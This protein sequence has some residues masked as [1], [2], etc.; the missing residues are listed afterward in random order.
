MSLMIKSSQVCFGC[1]ITNPINDYIGNHGSKSSSILRYCVTCRDKLLCDKKECTKCKLFL[2]ITKFYLLARA[3]SGLTSECIKCA[4]AVMKKRK[5]PYN[6]HRY[7]ES[8][9]RAL[10]KYKSNNKEKIK[11]TNR[12]RYR[13]KKAAKATLVSNIIC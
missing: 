11:A 2:P 4:L 6:Y 3:K 8:T 5:N 12:A 13:R 1:D 9:R 7:K 10:N